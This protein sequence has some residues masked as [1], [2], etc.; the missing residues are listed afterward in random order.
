[1]TISLLH[2]ADFPVTETFGCED[3]NT[4]IHPACVDISEQSIRY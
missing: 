2:I 1:M 3:C 4:E